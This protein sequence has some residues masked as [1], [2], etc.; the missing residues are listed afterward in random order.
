M[1]KLIILF[2]Q[3]TSSQLTSSQLTS[4]QLTSSQLTSNQSASGQSTSKHSTSRTK[5]GTTLCTRTRSSLFW[6]LFH[7]LKPLQKVVEEVE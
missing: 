4:S 3:L 7:F 2:K 6:T 5:R 1:L